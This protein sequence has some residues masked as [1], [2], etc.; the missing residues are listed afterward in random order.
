[1]TMRS[2][3]LS[4]GLFLTLSPT[5]FGQLSPDKALSTFSVADG[6]QIELF[7][8]E[9]MFVN[10]TIMDIDH[11]G[12]V[13]VCESVNYRTQLRKKPLN[14][15][16]GDR[17]VV[18]EDTDGDGKADKATTFYQDKDL[19]APLGIA[20][21]PDPDGKGCKVFVCHS[22]HIYVF[23]DKD[24]DLKADGP[25]KVLLTGFKGYDHDHG[26]HGILIGPDGK[27]YFSV[28]DQGVDGLKDK[29]GKVWKTNSTD[30]RAGTVW[31]CDLDGKNLELLAHNFR[32]NYE[33]CV[34]SFGN[35]FISDNDDDGNQQTRI[36]FVMPGGNYGYH[37]RGQGQTHWHE[38]QPGVVPKILR[39]YFGSPTGMCVYEGTLLP[40][41]YYGQPLHTDAGPRHL[42]CYHLKPNG[43]GY[44]VEREDM[45][46]STDSWFRPSDVCVAPDG[47][48]FI[49]D[50]YDPGVGGHGMADTTRGR[51]YRVTPKGH[52]GYKVPK[53]DMEKKEGI[54]AALA[55]PN[56]AV[57]HRAMAK[58][59]G[60]KA[61]DVLEVLKPA[62]KQQE[63]ASLKARAYWQICRLLQRKDGDKGSLKDIDLESLTND[64]DP[65]LRT[66]RVRIEYDLG[67]FRSPWHNGGIRRL[68]FDRSAAVRREWLL[69]LRHTETREAQHAIHSLALEYDGKDRFYLGAIG[70]AV[71]QDAERRNA[72]HALLERDFPKLN[73]KMLDLIW[74]LRPPSVMPSL[75]KW[76][77][78]AK[79][80][81]AQR[82]RIV[83]ILATS[84]DKNAGKAL[85]QVVKADAPREVRDRIVANLHLFLPGKWRDLRQTQELKDAIDQ[86]LSKHE[87]RGTGLGLMA[88]A[89]MTGAVGKIAAIASDAKE[90]PAVRSTAI[91]ALGL[92]YT[93][94]SVAA[95]ETLLK[96]DPPALRGEA[97]QALGT[98]TEPE[99][100]K[101]STEPALKALQKLAT[102]KDGDLGLRQDALA[103]LAGSRA[104]TEWLLDA[105]KKQVPEALRPDAARLL[106]NSPYADLRNRALVD[107]PPPPRKIDPKTIPTIA[108]LMSRKPDRENGK[109]LL[110]ASLKNDM[111][112]LRCHTVRGLGGAIG[113]DLSVIGTKASRENLFESILYPSKA[114][115]DQYLTWQ[116]ATKQGLSLTGLIMEETSDYLVLRDANGKDAK[117]DKKN[118]EA[119]EKSAS[120]LM[121]SDL[122]AYM[123]EEDLV[124]MVD[125]L[126]TLK[127]PA[128]ALD[129]WHV[130]GPFRGEPGE[131]HLDQVFGPEKGIDL[132]AV[133]DNK[134]GPVRWRTVKPNN[135][136]YVDLQAFLGKDSVNA[137][138]YVYGEIESPVDQEA[139]VLL[140]TD[141]GCKLWVNGRVVHT[142]HGTRVAV[143]E[144]DAIKVKLT[145]G[146][147]K[148]LLKIDNAE[149]AHGFYFTFLAEQELKRVENK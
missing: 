104:G 135:Q 11:K 128:L 101:P 18:L 93:V 126:L 20:V 59:E 89:E 130:A 100:K 3:L 36:C 134:A 66:V 63:N 81:T 149:G 147:N 90:P 99:A 62:L 136:G 96:T 21:A 15:A 68:S 144:E 1:M 72:V 45:V 102:A 39:T 58:F 24:G 119:R 125:Y 43:A 41:K 78:D 71:G 87:T 137:V 12:R 91:Q 27:L 56:Q 120:S 145:K 13:W 23:E 38:E 88:A 16:E 31:R 61:P 25:P 132:K 50:W 34:D 148:V 7:A 83:D 122:L 98:L 77:T 127:T 67:G 17:I 53:V 117:I 64:P 140:G 112:C 9:P 30:C 105:A 80:P 2:R 92:L 35:V 37:P 57:M 114:I 73:E 49:A 10:P 29:H 79:L 103:A 97:V 129:S 123:T 69:S 142:H 28:G 40:K 14:R 52:T 51:I 110:A 47:S 94:E 116:I 95:L 82:A 4:L 8:A 146:R 121:P 138:S 84:N 107:F 115:A 108:T 54:L 22:P 70:I 19:L 106:R 109:K 141:D 32:N 65:R 5:A 86:M 55:S 74:E 131:A 124:D 42:R 133:Y 46:T 76:L 118:I 33:P 48:V 44:D 60:M 113:P 143:P 139:T 111:Q 26:V 6:L 75:E 85:L